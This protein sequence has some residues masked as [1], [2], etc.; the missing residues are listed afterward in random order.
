MR[1]LTYSSRSAFTLIEL[2]VVIAIIAILIALLVPAVQKVREAAARTQCTNNL[3]QIALAIHDYEGANKKL[4]PAGRGYGWCRVLPAYPSDSVIVN[5]NGLTLLLPYLDQGALYAKFNTSQAYG[6]LVSPL[7]TTYW[8]AAQCTTSSRAGDASTNGNGA[9]ASTQLAVF[10][11]PSDSGD[12]VIPASTAYGPGGNLTGAKTNYDFIV[13]EW[14]YIYCNCWNSDG[15]RRYMF[16]QNSDCKI[17]QVTDGMS[18]TFMLGET[19][20]EVY[21]GR[22]SPWSYRGWVMVGIDPAGWNTS[23]NDWTW[24]SITPKIGQLGSWA[25]PG[26]LHSGG[27]QFAM[28]DGSVRFVNESTPRTTLEQMA[29]IAGNEVANTN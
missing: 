17:S 22:C 2:L 16:G 19:T 24:S 25:Y 27:C 9:L 20:L 12:P 29:T 6:N 4:P 3:K 15:I 1:R 11:C 10:R 18:N 21:N 14:D 5:S 26:S 8:P 28:G 7:N 23:I 13:R